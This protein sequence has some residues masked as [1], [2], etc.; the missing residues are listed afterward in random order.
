MFEYL[1][2]GKKFAEQGVN[3]FPLPRAGA[4]HLRK[5]FRELLIGLQQMTLVI[6]VDFHLNP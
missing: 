1:R 6:P 5:E 2:F 3:I 4:D